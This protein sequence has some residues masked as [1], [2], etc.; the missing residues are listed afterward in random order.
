MNI[1]GEVAKS[2]SFV[3]ESSPATE[4][5]GC[6]AEGTGPES[7]EG[8]DEFRMSSLYSQTLILNG[9][10]NG[11]RHVFCNLRTR[12]FT[13]YEN[14]CVAQCSLIILILDDTLQNIMIP[15]NVRKNILVVDGRSM[16]LY[17]TD[18]SIWQ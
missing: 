11:R 16:C 10:E 1:T 4:L 18:L 15:R 3:K 6:S 17:K 9:F 13:S 14:Y 2:S 12:A 5:F 8:L 7:L